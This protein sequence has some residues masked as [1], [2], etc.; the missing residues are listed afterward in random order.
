MLFF[1][2]YSSPRFI[3]HKDYKH[4]AK[5]SVWKYLLQSIF[6]W[7][8][9]LLQMGTFAYVNICIAKH[10]PH[11]MVTL[12]V[13]DS[14]IKQDLENMCIIR[15]ITC[16]YSSLTVTGRRGGQLDNQTFFSLW[17]VT[18]L[19]SLHS[20]LT[21]QSVCW[22]CVCS[23]RLGSSSIRTMDFQ[24]YLLFIPVYS[25]FINYS[26]QCFFLAQNKEVASVRWSSYLTI[27]LHL[28]L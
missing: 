23:S 24:G 4:S 13:A 11:L 3:I 15:I 8:I 25:K 22:V 20:T 26:L 19:V 9:R 1:L 12:Q 2:N 10:K 27:C 6:A 16:E 17:M 14:L 28:H 18:V 7:L 5:I 21:A